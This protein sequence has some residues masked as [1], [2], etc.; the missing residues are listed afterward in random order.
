MPTLPVTWFDRQE[1]DQ[2]FQ[3]SVKVHAREKRD[4][5]EWMQSV[6]YEDILRLC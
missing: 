1:I 3:K 2:D 6:K 5:I 4:L